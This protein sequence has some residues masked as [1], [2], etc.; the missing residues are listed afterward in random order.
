MTTKF[1]SSEDCPET[2]QQKNFNKC[3]INTPNLGVKIK[4]S[5]DN[6]NNFKNENKLKNIIPFLVERKFCYYSADSKENNTNENQDRS[7]YNLFD[8]K[9]PFF[10]ISCVINVLYL[11]QLLDSIEKFINAGKP[12]MLMETP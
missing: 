11:I 4:T 6:F 7:L 1:Y 5:D 10:S 2:G 8:A 3:I 9:N 12:F